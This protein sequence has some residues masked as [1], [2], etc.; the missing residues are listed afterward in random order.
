[1]RQDSTGSNVVRLFTSVIYE[2]SYLAR[3]FVPGK[4]FQPF[5]FVGFVGKTKSLPKGVTFLGAHLGQPPSLS[6]KH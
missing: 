5:L 1:M 2:C 6:H 4:P 3:V